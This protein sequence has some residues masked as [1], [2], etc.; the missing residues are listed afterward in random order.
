MNPLILIAAGLILIGLGSVGGWSARALSNDHRY[1]R[2]L[3]ER[4]ESA[5]KFYQKE[6]E[7]LAQTNEK[8]YRREA[9]GK[10]FKD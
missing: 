5:T 6:Y 2:A 3:A 1:I 10:K 4:D 7:L 9:N 8:L